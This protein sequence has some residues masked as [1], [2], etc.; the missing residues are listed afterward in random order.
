MTQLASTR[1]TDTPSEVLGE[2]LRAYPGWIFPR[3]DDR[4]LTAKWGEVSY[5]YGLDT[6]GINE[7]LRAI[8]KEKGVNVSTLQDGEGRVTLELLRL[9][10]SAFNLPHPEDAFLSPEEVRLVANTIS[11]KASIS[12]EPKATLPQ[13]P[14]LQPQN[15]PPP[16]TPQQTPKTNG[17]NPPG[18][19][20]V[21][22]TNRTTFELPNAGVLKG[23][24]FDSPGRT[25]FTKLYPGKPVVV[26]DAGHGGPDPGAVDPR[27]KKGEKHIALFQTRIV[28]QKL[29][30]A[31][32]NVLLTRNSDVEPSLSDRQALARGRAAFVSIHFNSATSSQAN[33]LEV[34]ARRGPS[35]AD[36]DLQRAV[37]KTLVPASSLYGVGNR[38]GKNQNFAVIRGSAPS[39][40]VEGGFL[41]NPKDSALL[42]N[43]PE[44]HL[45]Q[46]RAI[47]E[48]VLNFLQQRK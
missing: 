46:A 30:D 19:D 16:T 17:F 42:T 3:T 36:T 45:D 37:L 18:W 26:L 21:K 9:T 2:R 33:G 34:F 38:G 22:I 27:S 20:Q 15:P 11:K 12:P 25:D 48:G 8:L 13:I 10:R 29:I 24:I 31:G 6:K 23:I 39:I 14:P 32:Y 35:G 1:V 28:A 5:G 47:A 43:S 4:F 41:S 44:F 7:A 40:L